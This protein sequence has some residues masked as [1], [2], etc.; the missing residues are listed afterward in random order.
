[1]DFLRFVG[2]FQILVQVFIE[3]AKISSCTA[4]LRICWKLLVCGTGFHEIVGPYRFAL[5]IFMIF[6]GIIYIIVP[7]L[8]VSECMLQSLGIYW[9]IS[10]CC[11]GFHGKAEYV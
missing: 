1:M 8:Y 10:F 6:F 9:N 3:L 7:V 11:A 5:Q 4:D 2:S